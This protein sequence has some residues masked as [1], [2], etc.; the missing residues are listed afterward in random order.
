MHLAVYNELLKSQSL[1]FTKWIKIKINQ[2]GQPIKKI[3]YQAFESSKSIRAF[4]KIEYVK[5]PSNIG[6]SLHKL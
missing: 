5:N 1:I 6:L 2:I 4:F 3:S